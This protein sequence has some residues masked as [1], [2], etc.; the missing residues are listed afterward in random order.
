MRI[1][2]L[3]ADLM[4]AMSILNDPCMRRSASVTAVQYYKEW[5]AFRLYACDHMG[6]FGPIF[7]FQKSANL[8]SIQAP[9]SLPS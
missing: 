8:W 6:D 4:T 3:S 1:A 7:H 9:P 2:G 5:F